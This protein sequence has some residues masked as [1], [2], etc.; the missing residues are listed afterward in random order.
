MYIY[1]V[2][3]EIN[4]KVYIG[5]STVKSKYN[6]K[7]YYGSGLLIKKA[8]KKYGKENFRKEIL[9]ESDN[10]EELK[11]ME[12]QLIRESNELGEDSYNIAEGGQTGHWTHYKTEEELQDIRERQ[13]L[14]LR[15]W[16]EEN[17][18]PN[19]GKKLASGPK[20]SKALKGR[21][22]PRS[23]VE[24]Q[25]KAKTGKKRTDEQKQNISEAI[26]EAY[27]DGFSEEHRNRIS[28]ALSGR[29]IP[30]EV[31]EKMRRPK[32]KYECPHC[33]KIGGGPVMKRHHFDN[34]KH[35]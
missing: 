24:K 27:K 32:P 3:N 33:G 5:L 12:I 11:E 22:V 31:K 15:E 13:A 10:I 6:R 7:N 16:Y 35:Q 34:C 4:D 1:K 14:S 8:L 19:L 21:K 25:R 30:E 2:T 17:D 18:H 29:V 26:K 28:K 20:I 23:V 9:F